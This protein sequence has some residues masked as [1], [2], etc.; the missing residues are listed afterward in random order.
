MAAGDVKLM[1]TVG[2]FLG[3]AMTFQAGLAT[4]CAGGLL[5]LAI[6]LAKGRAR[7]ALGNVRALLLPLVLR[8]GGL[9]AAHAHAGAAS[10]GGMPYAL[11]ISAGTV[12]V[13]LL[14]HM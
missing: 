12:G 9:R 8:N 14:R 10:V 4:Y 7:A 2:A 3:P 11:A 5:A 6:V 1:A 13:L